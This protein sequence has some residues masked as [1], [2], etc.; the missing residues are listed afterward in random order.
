[1]KTSQKIKALYLIMAVLVASSCMFVVMHE[2]IHLALSDEANGICFGLCQD[3]G[4]TYTNY[5]L[6]YGK[7]NELSRREDIPT[8]VGLATA[9]V[10]GVVGVV[11]VMDLLFKGG[12]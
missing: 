7:H 5:G 8:Y 1:M 2:V 12:D 9:C 6:A 4:Y 3:S 10:F 11:F